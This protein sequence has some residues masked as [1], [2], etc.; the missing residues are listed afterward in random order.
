MYG[1]RFFLFANRNQERIFFLKVAVDTL[2]CNRYTATIKHI[3]QDRQPDKNCW[4]KCD[5]P[6]HSGC[7]PSKWR[8]NR[9]MLL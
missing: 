7:S 3:K 1:V 2:Y 9:V 5:C 4:V 8:R 6:L